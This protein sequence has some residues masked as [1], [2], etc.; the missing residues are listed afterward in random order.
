MKRT[1]SRI[2][3]ILLISMFLTGCGASKSSYMDEASYASDTIY[4]YDSAATTEA[5]AQETGE[6]SGTENA[7]VVPD[8]ER[9]LIKNVTLQVETKEFDTLLTNVETKV[10]QLGGYIQNYNTYNNGYAETQVYRGADLTLRI[11]VE[12]LD[13]FVTEVAAI[14]NVTSRNESV[15]DVTLQYVDLESHK[16]AL[17]AEYDRL[18]E[19]L[20]QAETVEDIIALEGR[21]SEVRYQMESMESQLRTYDNQIDYSTVYLYINEVVE[22]T[23]VEEQGILTRI[24][25]GFVKSLANVGNGLL[26]F[27]IGIIVYLPYIVV[28]GAVIALICFIIH[29]CNKRSKTKRELKQAQAV[30]Q[31]P[32]VQEQKKES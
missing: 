32:N 4:N 29:K 26:D 27:G 24:G 14:S 20:E 31:M 3:T 2:G 8:S 9:K 15:E 21:L 1:F 22:L 16:K 5:V 7:E 28:W 30:N 10:G 25:T 13:Q 19:L 6:I 12:Q 23:P 17:Q 18:I 11:P